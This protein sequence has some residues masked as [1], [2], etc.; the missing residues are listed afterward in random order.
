MWQSTNTLKRELQKWK[1]QTNETIKQRNKEQSQEYKKILD[2]LKKINQQ[3]ID[4]ENKIEETQ[5]KNLQEIEN[6]KDLTN[7][8]SK[9]VKLSEKY[10]KEHISDTNDKLDIL[11]ERMTKMSELIVIQNAEI[12]KEYEELQKNMLMVNE[13]TRLIIAN[14]L[15]N[16]LEE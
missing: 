6:L 11:A 14:M 4:Q 2:E 9:A 3:F 8:L 7:Q 16:N 1:K 10:Q 13:A 12:Q 15:L 5:S